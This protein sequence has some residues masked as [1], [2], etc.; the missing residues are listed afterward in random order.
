MSLLVHCS[1]IRARYKQGSVY[2]QESVLHSLHA[3]EATHKL[4]TSVVADEIRKDM[5]TW[6]DA[7]LG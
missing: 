7:I 5:V 6:S 2:T 4:V 1:D 3:L